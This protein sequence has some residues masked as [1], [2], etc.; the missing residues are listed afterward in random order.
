M[1]IAVTVMVS[2]LYVQLGE[3][4]DSLLLLRLEETALGAGVAIAV[5]TLVF[6][7]GPRRVL[8]V[9]V[10]NYIGPLAGLVDRATARLLA[11]QQT[12]Q[13]PLRTDARVLDAS[14]QALIT[15]A[16]PLR[17]N[18]FGSLDAQTGEGIPLASAARK[19][20]RNLVADVEDVAAL[21]AGTSIEIERAGAALRG[22]MA[23]VGEA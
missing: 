17:R 18:L 6:P 7:L 14:Y 8:R 22:S 9:A 23:I 21:D 4:S 20:G 5:V 10:R 11:D 12:A 2:Q 15:T 16:K 19:Y 13:S 1:A 3:F